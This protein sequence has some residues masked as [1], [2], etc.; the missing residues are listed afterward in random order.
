[1]LNDLIFLSLIKSIAQFN[2]SKESQIFEQNCLFADFYSENRKLLKYVNKKLRKC[3][4][5]D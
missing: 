2:N 4:T 3:K 5:M 1:M